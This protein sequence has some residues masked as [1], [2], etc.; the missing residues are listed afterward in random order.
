VA[1]L[2]G[3]AGED[4]DAFELALA[5][6]EAV[7]PPAVVAEVMSAPE[8][9]ATTAALLDNLRMLPIVDGYWVRVG[10]ARRVMRR[11]GR[12]ARLGDALISQS[13]IDHNVPLVTRDGDFRAYAEFCGL[14]LT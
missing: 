1:Y 10:G 13:C 5:A 2:A 12:R 4:V 3:E 7:L 6:E 11:H 14:K 8:A 9:D